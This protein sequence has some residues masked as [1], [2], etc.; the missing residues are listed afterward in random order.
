MP[1]E[2][3]KQTGHNRYADI[4][5][6]GCTVYELLIGKPP[7]SEKK[8]IFNVLLAIANATE[9]PKLPSKELVSDDL[10][11]FLDC[12]FKRDPYQRA[13]VHELLRHP[14]I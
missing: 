10:K 9:P 12:C 7:W 1:P 3:V 6:L 11:S 13:N 14:F 4:W 5:S 2:V 8:D